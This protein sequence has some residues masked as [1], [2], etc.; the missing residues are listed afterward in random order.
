MSTPATRALTMES[1][2]PIYTPLLQLWQRYRD[3]AGYES[4]N[5]YA[6]KITE[7]VV[8]YAPAGTVLVRTTRRP[9]GAVI[10]IPDFPYDVQLFVHRGDYGW[11]SVR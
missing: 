11:K 10:H 3:E 6:V 8:K 4:W 1:M 9:F 7:Y 2:S 5:D